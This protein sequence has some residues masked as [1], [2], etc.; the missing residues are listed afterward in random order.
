MVNDMITLELSSAHPIGFL[1]ELNI[2]R[3]IFCYMHTYISLKPFA[4]DLRSLSATMYIVR[5]CIVLLY[6]SCIPLNF[7]S[8]GHFLSLQLQ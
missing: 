7:M 1:S 6:T 5:I 8:S 4:F 2:V 3:E